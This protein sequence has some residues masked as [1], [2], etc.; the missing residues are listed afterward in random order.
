[1]FAKLS[2]SFDNVLYISQNIL[3]NYEFIDFRQVSLTKKQ[4]FTF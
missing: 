4:Y 1:M 3:Y 2:I